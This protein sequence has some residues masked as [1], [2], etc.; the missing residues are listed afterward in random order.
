MTT[1]QSNLTL[2]E[3][4]RRAH[5]LFITSDQAPILHLYSN[6]IVDVNAENL[7]AHE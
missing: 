2:F 6:L 7:A 5:P 4:R 3:V 1:I